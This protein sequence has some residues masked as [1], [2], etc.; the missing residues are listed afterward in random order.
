M[1]WS[2]LVE[3]CWVLECSLELPRDKVV[4]ALS[5]L[6]VIDRLTVP[7]EKNFDWCVERYAEGADFADMVHLVAAL[8]GS[9]DFAPFDRKL[10]RQ[11]GAST[12]LPVVLLNPAPSAP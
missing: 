12:P 2:V 3:L 1:G 11:A 6:R 10:L 4:A 8:V 7:H 9:S 5:T